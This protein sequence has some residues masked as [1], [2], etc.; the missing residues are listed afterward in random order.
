MFTVQ[1]IP[2]WGG[3]DFTN[4]GNVINRHATTKL[5]SVQ[6]KKKLLYFS[7]KHQKHIY[8]TKKYPKLQI[9]YSR[10]PKYSRK[11]AS[12]NEDYLFED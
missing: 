5:V 11:V 12:L 9:I 2:R 4:I 10:N 1:N 3:R 6:K 7:L 8:E